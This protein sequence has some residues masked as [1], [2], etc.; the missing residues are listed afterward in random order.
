MPTAKKLNGTLRAFIEKQK[1]FFVATA[2]ADGRVNLS[3]KGMDSLRIID[4]NRI[5]WLNLTG[6]GNETAAHLRDVNRMT[7]MFCA[8]EGDALILR[9]YGQA[10]TLH[11]A[12]E[13]WDAAIG[14]FPEMAGSRQIFD[15]TIDLV[16][17]SCGTGVPVMSFAYDRGPAELLPYYA[18]MGTDGV[19]DF[20]NRRNSESIDGKPT[21]IVRRS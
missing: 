3:P 6:S 10:Q 11:P 7:L 20:W 12:D 5:V 19:E 9:T 2:T 15:M 13:G 14:H 8:F 21:G 18:D 17:T 16:Q 4:D 1:L